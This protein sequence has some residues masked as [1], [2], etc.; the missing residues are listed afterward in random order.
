MCDSQKRLTFLTGSLS[1]AAG[2]VFETTRS[3]AIAIKKESRYLPTV[4]GLRDSET[5][6]DRSLWEDIRTETFKVRGPRGFGYAPGLRKALELG[7]PQILHVHGLW[8][9]SSI[10]ALSWSGSTKPYI[11]S[12]HGMLD[13]WALNNS[14][15]KKRICAAIYERRHLRGAACVHALNQAEA[16][17]IRSYGLRNPIC[18]IPNGVALP[19]G[20]EDGSV[21]KGRTL[22]Y[23]GR[24]HPKK[25]LPKLIEAWSVARNGT[26]EPGWQLAIAGWDENGHRNELEMLTA[27][28][29]VSASVSIVGPQFGTAKAE[30]FTEA[31]AF[32]LPSLSEGMPITVLEA[33]SWRLP[34]LMTPHCNLAEGDAAGAAIMMEPEVHSIS[35]ALRRL[36]SMSEAERE[37]MG[38]NGRRLVEQRFQ[39]S[40][41]GRQ[42]ADV[43][44]WMLGGPRPNT[45]E[46]FE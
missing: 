15:W 23:L 31:S 33:W 42:M 41:I 6:R 9:Y 14:R 12:P 17:A 29:N 30:C 36:F 24:L 18:V 3:L 13:S 11:V 40:Q 44:D 26:T 45:V 7:N 19:S 38:M 8:M 16:A 46:V 35:T 28:F 21:R 43:Y 5:G 4:V 39:W 1:R 10:A 22:L 27:R 2:G 32:V 37:A 34:V 25:G 20:A